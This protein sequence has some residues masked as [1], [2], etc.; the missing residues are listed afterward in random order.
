MKR[1]YLSASLFIVVLVLFLGLLTACA[2][3]SLPGATAT[4]SDTPT[5]AVQETPTAPAETPVSSEAAPTDAAS[6]LVGAPWLAEAIVDASGSLTPTLVGTTISAT[7]ADGSVTGSAGCNNYITT[8]DATGDSIKFGPVVT[9]RKVCVEPGG[10][11]EQETAYTR[12]LE[13]TAG[14]AIADG[15]LRLLDADGAPLV[16]YITT[17]PAANTLD[18][19]VLG[20]M[21]YQSTVSQVGEVTLTDGQSLKTTGEGATEQ[22]STMLTDKVAVGDLNSV[23][24]AAVVLATNTGGSGVFM[25]LAV[26]QSVDGKPTNVATTS[27]GDR[28]SI[29]SLAIE[30][31]QILVEMVTHGPDDPL[32]CP[33]QHVMAAYELQNG[34]LK[35]VALQELGTVEPESAPAEAMTTTVTAGEAMTATKSADLSGEVWQ[36]LGTTGGTAKAVTPKFPEKYTLAF[37]LDGKVTLRADCNR[38]GGTYQIDGAKLTIDA[39]TLTRKACPQG[40]LGNR[41]VHDLNAV[42]SRTMTDGNLVLTLKAGA[43]DMKFEP[44]PAPAEEQATPAAAEATPATPEAETTPEA[45]AEVTPEATP[46]SESESATASTAITDTTAAST[47]MTDTTASPQ[48]TGV[49]WEWLGTT[50]SNDKQYIVK[51]P[52][53]YSVLFAADGTAQ[54]LADCNNGSGTYQT[55]GSSLSLDVAATTKKACEA[56]SKAKKFIDELNQA[57]SYVFDGENLVINLKVDTGNMTFQPAP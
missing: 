5:L 27:L 8:F 54:L 3:D 40:S 7:F 37:L 55:E 9:T 16:R 47:A 20:N 1:T 51:W 45:T 26:V 28:V 2:P 43:G 50:Y 22:V 31:N 21:A 35:Q 49:V 52:A 11:M 53:R 24:S 39:A 12:S 23:A 57:A 56:D 48:L 25:D 13:K 42:A 29:D 38:G 18:A 10:V 34:E 33:T 6:G 36:W 4:P 14:Y 17:E 30:N 32:C 44:Q 41:F 46:V 19:A 15:K